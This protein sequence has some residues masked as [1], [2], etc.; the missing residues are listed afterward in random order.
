[1]G[2]TLNKSQVWSLK[3]VSFLVRLRTYQ[4][5][6][7]E[8]IFPNSFQYSQHNYCSSVDIGI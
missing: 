8:T 2:N 4:Q 3:L 6:P 1:V 5:P 7:V